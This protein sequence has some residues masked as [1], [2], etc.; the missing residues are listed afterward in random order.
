MTTYKV[1]RPC[2]WSAGFALIPN[3]RIWAW[4]KEK[5]PN[6]DRLAP[7]VLDFREIPLCSNK[8]LCWIRISGG[9]SCKVENFALNSHQ[10]QKASP[11]WGTKPFNQSLQH[12]TGHLQTLL[13]PGTSSPVPGFTR[14]LK[15]KQLDRCKVMIPFYFLKMSP[16]THISQAILFNPYSVDT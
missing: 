8:S 3:I 4:L 9:L 6:S 7:Q 15:H 16:V 11:R 12:T 1:T 5:R 10:L 13:L 2:F 14:C